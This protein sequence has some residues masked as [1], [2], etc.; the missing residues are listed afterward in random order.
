MCNTE[1]LFA[2]SC[3]SCSSSSGL[4]GPRFDGSVRSK[5]L[6]TLVAVFVAVTIIILLLLHLVVLLYCSPSAVMGDYCL[7]GNKT[8]ERG[9]HTISQACLSAWPCQS[10]RPTPCIDLMFGSACNF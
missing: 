4:R 5:Q 8:Q 2:I 1:E 3:S 6:C 9:A 7:T 10:A